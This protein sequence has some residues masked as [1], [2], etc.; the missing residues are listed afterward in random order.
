MTAAARAIELK[1][2][3]AIGAKIEATRLCSSLVEVLHLFPE[4]RPFVD[5]QLADGRPVGSIHVVKAVDEEA[6]P[7]QDHAREQ[8]V[9]PPKKRVMSKA[10][11]ARISRAQKKRWRAIREAQK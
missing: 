10:A 6:P 11:R 1:A 5:K 7:R 9:P 4:L 8:P 2:F 3:A